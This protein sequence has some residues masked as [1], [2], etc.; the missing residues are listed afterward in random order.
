MSSNG[1]KWRWT[2]FVVESGLLQEQGVLL[3]GTDDEGWDACVAAPAA[4]GLL[5]IWTGGRYVM[6]PAAAGVVLSLESSSGCFGRDYMG[7]TRFR[8]DR[9]F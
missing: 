5:G 9:G 6:V 4:A 7:Y 8:V 1:D 2:P 3:L